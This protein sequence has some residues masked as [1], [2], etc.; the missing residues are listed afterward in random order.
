VEDPKLDEAPF[1][2]QIAKYLGTEHVEYHC[3]W[4][5]ALDIIPELPYYYDE[6]FAD[7][8]SIPTVL[9]SRL[10]RKEVTVALSA[11]AGDEV[12]SGYRRYHTMSTVSRTLSHIPKVI[13]NSGSAFME[14]FNPRAFPLL[15]KKYSFTNRYAKFSKLLRNP[16]IAEVLKSG[17][18]QF[19]GQN[20]EKLLAVPVR[21]Q[22][23]AFDSTELQLDYF[24]EE[25]YLMSMD[26]QTFLPDDILQKVD[27]ATMSVSLEGREPF[28]D[29]H[30]LEWAAQLPTNFKLNAGISKYILREIVHRHIPKQIM[31]RPKMGFCI[32]IAS[33]LEN[34]LKHLLVRYFDK[35]FVEQ[36]GLFKATEMRRIMERFLNGRQERSEK[37]WCILMF[38]MWY[39]KWMM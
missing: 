11:D 23:T 14:L 26:F 29:Q 1:A 31:D 4:K 15:G 20:I 24:E 21:E 25:L 9:V 28:L 12:F 8:S 5:E 36:Q 27:R 30:I 37:I 17:M 39:E 19:Y 13:R 34:E 18:H 22:A 6:P 35:N 2:K 16:E 10:A 7:S 38:Q 3:T 32:P 33:W